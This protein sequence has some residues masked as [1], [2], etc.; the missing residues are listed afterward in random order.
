[1][2][3]IS[4]SIRLK[5]VIVCGFVPPHF[6]ITLLINF[7]I[8]VNKFR[9]WYFHI[10]VHDMYDKLW[11]YDIVTSLSW[12]FLGSAQ[13]MFSEKEIK[14]K[15]WRPYFLSNFNDS[16]TILK[17]KSLLCIVK[18]R[19]NYRGPDLR[20]TIEI[21]ISSFLEERMPIYNCQ[22]S[23]CELAYILYHLGEITEH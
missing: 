1:M 7:L 4:K 17:G 2:N 22:F 5:I 11:K 23:A 15:S 10:L 12:I 13:D 3:L 21:K 18:I 20:F 14:K 8:Q 9:V 16:Y 6:L 19:N